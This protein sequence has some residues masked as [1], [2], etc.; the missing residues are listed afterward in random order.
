[1]PE[2][3]NT[4]AETQIEQDGQVGTQAEQEG[5]APPTV[6]PG[7]QWCIV[8]A[9]TNKENRVMESLASGR[10]PG[11]GRVMVPA[12]AV[13]V[14][15][16]GVQRVVE[17]RLY[18]GYVFAEIALEDGLLT[19]DMWYEIGGITGCIGV[20]GDR[21]PAFV[22]E[23]EAEAMLADAD[24]KEKRV[25]DP[26]FA[27]GDLVTV[28]DGSFEGHEGVVEKM[29]ARKGMATVDIVIFGRSTPVDIEVWQLEK[30]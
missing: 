20:L 17:R 29:D 1:M 21:K 28:R 22:S 14:S 11:I 3:E 27:P 2:S 13:R 25:K 4:A 19:D 23:A 24:R 7:M 30:A 6:T 16:G 9:A 18:P 15:R 10:I 12:E 26:D 5:Q 8:R